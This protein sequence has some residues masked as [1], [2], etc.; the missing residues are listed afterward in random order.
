M[1][2][3]RRLGRDPEPNDP[4]ISLSRIRVAAVRPQA[5][6]RTQSPAPRKAVD[7]D[8]GGVDFFVNHGRSKLILLND[9]DGDDAL[10]SNSNDLQEVYESVGLLFP[11]R[12][13]KIAICQEFS[14]K[15]KEYLNPWVVVPL[16]SYD[17]KDVHGNLYYEIEAFHGLSLIHI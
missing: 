13:R 16:C 3:G 14:D 8:E 15:N 1:A 9:T 12:T 17:Q 11:K 4:D 6:A 7:R 5:K 10:D 2:E